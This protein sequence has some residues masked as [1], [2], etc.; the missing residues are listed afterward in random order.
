MNKQ[1]ETKSENVR[2]AVAARKSGA[3]LDHAS[4]PLT[5]SPDPGKVDPA[6][7][8]NMQRI[9]G[10]KTVQ[11]YLDARAMNRPFA[12]LLQ[13]IS[14]GMTMRN[15]QPPPVQRMYIPPPSEE[16]SCADP[17]ATPPVTSQDAPTIADSLDSLGHHANQQTQ[18]NQNT[19]VLPETTVTGTTQRPTLY[20]GSTGPYVELLQNKLRGAGL[21]IQ[22]DGIFGSGTKA[23]VKQF[24]ERM[25]LDADGVVG[26]RTWEALDAVSR[27]EA[28]SDAE[29]EQFFGQITAARALHEAG[30]Y[31]AALDAY[32]ALYADPKL[33]SK[34]MLLTNVIWNIATVHH[35][36]A[37]AADIAPEQKQQRLD[38]AISWYQ[39]CAMRE[40]VKSDLIANT[41]T[42]IR[43]CRLGQPPTSVL[44]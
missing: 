7:I 35:Q 20:Q 40:G 19:T 4:Q 11:R 43:E 9:L 42:R 27:G 26:R 44:N 39:E 32:F 3:V 12:P 33:A 23:K 25:K 34:P 8:L 13:K 17:Y 16:F 38:Q 10:N 28:I 2:Q 5:V 6:A 21:G 37:F 29:E 41:A 36:M 1:P 24:Q 18:Q 14:P 31:Q 30:Q 15:G 22:V